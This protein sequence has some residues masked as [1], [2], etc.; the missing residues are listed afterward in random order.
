MIDDAIYSLLSGE[1]TITDIVSTRIYPSFAPIDST[2]PLVV[3]RKVSTTGRSVPHSGAAGIARSQY[4]FSCVAT[5]AIQSKQ[6]ADA[7]RGLLHG[8]SG[9]I[10]EDRIF[11]AQAV[12]EIDLSDEELGF[13]VAL[14][15]L[16]THAE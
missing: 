12:N 7:I 14:D 13:A 16:F 15:V 6:L 4:Q 9:T 1:S 5:T 11:V 2:I 8:Y 3:Y 10:D